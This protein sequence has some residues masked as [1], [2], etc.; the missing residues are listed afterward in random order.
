MQKYAHDRLHT[1]ERPFHTKSRRS[2]LPKLGLIL[3]VATITAA[4]A[5]QTAYGCG[6]KN[7]GGNNGGGKNGGGKNGGGQGVAASIKKAS[8]KATIQLQGTKAT[9]NSFSLSG[10]PKDTP[11]IIHIHAQNTESALPADK[12]KGPVL[13]VIKNPEG[14]DPIIKTAG[15]GRFSLKKQAFDLAPPAPGA[16]PAPPPDLSKIDTWYVNVHD[17]TK[18][19]PIP[20]GSPPGTKPKFASIA[21]GLIKVGANATKGSATLKADAAPPPPALAINSRRK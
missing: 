20:A 12:C 6:G 18:P 7:G 4:I 5:V 13:F 11:L 16:A 2:R 3:L 9:L 15:D 14:G 8:G 1:D 10:G 21:C 19:L 17:A